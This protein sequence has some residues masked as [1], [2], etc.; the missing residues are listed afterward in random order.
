[1]FL[2]IVCVCSLLTCLHFCLSRRTESSR[3]AGSL[4]SLSDAPPLK[5]G[6]GSLAG[7]PPLKGPTDIGNGKD[8]DL[9]DLKT[10][11]EKIG[12]LGLGV[13]DDYD[14]DDFNSTS[15]RSDKTKS[16]V[17][18]GEEIEEELSIEGV[19]FN[20]SDKVGSV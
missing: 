8:I 11:N 1:M 9:K 6:L 20:A 10:M 5:T 15:H 14:D 17:S 16:E 3:P 19:D 18:I 2:F 13:E 4:A 7:V 12:S